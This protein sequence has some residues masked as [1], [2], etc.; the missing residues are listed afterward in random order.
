MNRIEGPHDLTPE[1]RKYLLA[2]R[3]NCR[4]PPT[5]S[6]VYK[7][8]WPLYL[9]HATFFGLMMSLCVAIERYEA[10]MFLGGMF[11]GVTARDYGFYSS[12]IRVWPA[13]SAIID[14]KKL[15]ELIQEHPEDP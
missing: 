1:Q 2:V 5:L 13:G 10:A 4:N 14:R 7:K 12:V 6:R 8:I 11:I 9:A 15:A 3:D